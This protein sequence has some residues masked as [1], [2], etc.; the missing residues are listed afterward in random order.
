M[1][2]AIILDTIYG[3]QQDKV[4]NAQEY[5]NIKKSNWQM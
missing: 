1:H 2:I 4:Q 3:N 5:W